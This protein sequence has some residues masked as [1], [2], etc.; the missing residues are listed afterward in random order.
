MDLQRQAALSALAGGVH[1][2]VPHGPAEML[3]EA[4]NHA[5]PRPQDSKK[6]AFQ[7]AAAIRALHGTLAIA[8][9]AEAPSAAAGSASGAPSGSR[10]GRAAAGAV[11]GAGQ[12][13]VPGPGA[14]ALSP[15]LT[16]AMRAGHA[17]GAYMATLSAAEGAGVVHDTQRQLELAARKLRRGCGHSSGSDPESG[18]LPEILCRFWQYGAALNGPECSEQQPGG[19]RRGPA[20]RDADAPLEA[21]SRQAEALVAK[22]MQGIVLDALGMRPCGFPGLAFGSAVC[23]PAGAGASG[24]SHQAP[25]S[26]AALQ[27]NPLWQR[28]VC[29]A[30]GVWLDG[31]QAAAGE[32]EALR[33]A[34][35]AAAAARLATVALPAG[36]R[37]CPPGRPHFLP[38]VPPSPLLDGLAPWQQLILMGEVVE[39]LLE[40]GWAAGAAGAAGAAC[41]LKGS[42]GRGLMRAA[43]CAC[44]SC[45]SQVLDSCHAVHFAAC[46]ACIALHAAPSCIMHAPAIRPHTVLLQRLL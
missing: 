23:G 26:F 13:P 37:A 36:G 41:A 46:G 22:A 15:A 33:G 39:G 19:T 9:A 27:A 31:M 34:R 6:S 5:F 21:W 43:S 42:A 18:M 25:A 2:W 45:C 17:G 8:A 3:I 40:P 10:G 38:S 20:P 44:S 28:A 12:A 30:A 11:T 4:G 29:A 16:A 14:M 24:S 7:V 1:T 32:D 35:Q